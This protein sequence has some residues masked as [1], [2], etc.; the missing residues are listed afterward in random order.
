M[1]AWKNFGNGHVIFDASQS[2]SPT[3]TTVNNTNATQPWVATFPS[4]MGWNGTST[5]GVRVD[6]ARNADT[7]DNIDSTQFLRSDVNDVVTA[8]ITFNDNKFLKFGTG[9]DVE[10]FCNGAHMYTDLNSGIGNWIIRDGTTN[11][12]TFDDNGTFTATNKIKVN[13]LEVD[14]PKTYMNAG[15]QTITRQGVSTYINSWTA[16]NKTYT[17]DETTFITGDKVYVSKLWDN[18][19][20]LTITSGVVIYLPTGGVG[21][22]TSQTLSVVGTVCFEYIGYAWMARA[23]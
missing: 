13:T 14:T 21:V 15:T 16:G 1:L 7:L 9:N 2:T 17:L 6:S 23:S 3:G 10:F 22:S 12:F 19:Y 8:N 18:T 11:R 20:T 5:F 4:L